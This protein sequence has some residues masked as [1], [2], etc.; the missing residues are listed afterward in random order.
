MATEVVS[1]IGPV[2]SGKSTVV[3]TFNPEGYVVVRPGEILRRMIGLQAMMSDPVPTA[4]G[5]T[6]DAVK[7]LVEIGMS[8]AVR[9]NRDLVLDGYPRTPRQV[10]ELERIIGPHPVSFV[11]VDAADDDRYLRVSSR[12]GGTISS[13][14]GIRFSESRLLFDE[15]I[16][17]IHRRFVQDARFKGMKHVGKTLG[18]V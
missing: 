11:L 16:T 6:D 10:D 5:L 8:L 2:G 12:N 17:S 15:T 9:T 1:V 4:C 14:D 13:F 3:E 18:S 7:L